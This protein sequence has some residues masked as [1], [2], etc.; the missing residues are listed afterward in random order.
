MV[1][2]RG[3]VLDELGHDRKQFVHALEAGEQV[4]GD[5][6]DS[7]HGATAGKCFHPARNHADVACAFPL[8]LDAVPDRLAGF[9]GG[10]HLKLPAVLSGLVKSLLELCTTLGKFFCEGVHL[11]VDTGL[12][13]LCIGSPDKGALSHNACDGL[14]SLLQGLAPLDL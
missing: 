4:G 6:G 12:G 2:R 1:N 5:L 10:K 11:L 8:A 7:S 9:L 13:L 3:N 14:G